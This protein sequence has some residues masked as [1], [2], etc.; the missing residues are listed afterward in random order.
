[1]QN[2]SLRKTKMEIRGKYIIMIKINNSEMQYFKIIYLS[3]QF[4]PFFIFEWF[5]AYI[6]ATYLKKSS[7]GDAE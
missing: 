7:S 4:L 6:E 2:V 1:M 5:C 3:P